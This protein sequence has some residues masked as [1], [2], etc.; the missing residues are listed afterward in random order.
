LHLKFRREFVAI[1]ELLVSAL[2]IRHQC[3]TRSPCEP[4]LEIVYEDWLRR[5]IACHE[6]YHLYLDVNGWRCTG[7][8]PA[9]VHV[10]KPQPR[11]RRMIEMP[12]RS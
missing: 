6:L 12:E 9:R 1:R 7:K 11:N 10:E 5:G 2:A 8:L 3:P 4:L